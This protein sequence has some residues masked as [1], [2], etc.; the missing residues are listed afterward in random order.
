M[1][2]LK[3]R[4]RRVG[5]AG[6]TLLLVLVAGAVAGLRYHNAM[7]ATPM[8]DIPAEATLDVPP[9]TTVRRISAELSARGWLPHARLFEFEARRQ[10]VTAQIRAGEYAIPQSTSPRELLARLVAGDTL[11]YRIT[12]VE[13]QRARD[14]IEAIRTHP[15]VRVVQPGA[16]TGMSDDEL[17]TMYALPF[18]HPEGALFPDTYVFERN[19]TDVAL[20]EQARDRLTD[21]LAKLWSEHGEAS[22]LNTPYEALILAS[23]IEKETGLAAER[24]TIAGVFLRRLE[25][26]MR[27]QTD[28]TVIYGIG[29]HFDGNLT[30]R[31]LETDTPYNTYTRPGLPPTPIA[32][33]GQAA[34]EAALQP[35][36]GDALYFVA[37]GDGS[38]HFSRT[39]AE[40]QRAVRTYQLGDKSSKRAAIDEA[41]AP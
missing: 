14:A 38:H 12:L 28:P 37:K 29:T 16:V 25:K 32:L 4:W 21:T 34:I 36:P 31:H 30:R 24:P 17:I 35:A 8:R 20:V 10:G 40:H 23:I 2:A 39:Y 33:V 1:R 11:R 15:K 6:F 7:M 18:P 19:T 3:G 5:L 41:S 9:G 26:G 13:G 22:S 27:L